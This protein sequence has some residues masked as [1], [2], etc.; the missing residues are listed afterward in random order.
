MWQTLLPEVPKYLIQGKGLGYDV[1][2]SRALEGFYRS[3]RQTS[4][5]AALAG[6]YHNGPLSVLIPFGLFGALGFVWFISASWRALH[7]NYKYGDPELRKA[8]MLLL[9]LFLA[10]LT[11]FMVIF[12]GFYGDLAFFA[13]LVGFS[14]AINGG[15]RQPVVQQQTIARPITLS[16]G[17]PRRPAHSFS[18]HA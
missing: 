7:Q 12:G 3:D 5:S 15:I 17:A 2:D 1:K 14:L 13:G 4:A 9:S 8:N 18:R 6:D 10:K 11:L 16:L